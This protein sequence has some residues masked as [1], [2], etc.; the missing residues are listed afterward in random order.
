M[1]SN[2]FICIIFSTVNLIKK[3]FPGTVHSRI[4]GPDKRILTIFTHMTNRNTFGRLIL[5]IVLGLI[6]GGVLG[7]CLG[8]LFGE[9]GEL[10][11]A[12]GYDNIVRNFFV[13][14]F[15]LNLGFLGDKANPVV[16]DLYM[17]K[18][19]LGFGLKI[20]VVSI[21]GMVVAIYIMKWSGGNR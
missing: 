1:F 12:G 18:L 7:E 5:F 11:N 14:S 2:F 15:D 17:V 3:F 16:L 21:V 13:A 9:L 19:A 20:N 6:I 8:L 4:S 10:M